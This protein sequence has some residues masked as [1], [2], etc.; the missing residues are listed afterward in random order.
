MTNSSPLILTPLF[1]PTERDEALATVK[2]LSAELYE[3]T[4]AKKVSDNR[5]GELE[6]EISKL[7]AGNLLT[8]WFH[9]LHFLICIT[10]SNARVASLE[11]DIKDIQDNNAKMNGVF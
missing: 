3:I 4:Q 1:H 6:K 10:E 9:I 2:K 11:R 7:T 5:A 8:F